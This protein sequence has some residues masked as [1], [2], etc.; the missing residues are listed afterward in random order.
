M[1]NAVYSRGKKSVRI[2]ISSLKTKL[3]QIIFINNNS[4]Q[5]KHNCSLCTFWHHSNPSSMSKTFV[6][7]SLYLILFYLSVAITPSFY[8]TCLLRWQVDNCT[9]KSAYTNTEYT[10]LLLDQVGH[11]WSWHIIFAS[12]S[13]YYHPLIFYSLALSHKI[14]FRYAFNFSFHR[15]EWNVTTFS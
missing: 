9:E 14:R 12:P 8:M 6:S 1:I 15:M 2:I 3:Y 13:S 11:F 7:V 4:I 5:I 10:L